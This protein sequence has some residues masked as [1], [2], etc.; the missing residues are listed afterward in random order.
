MCWNGTEGSR[1]ASTRFPGGTSNFEPGIPA[2]A[3]E[4]YLILSNYSSQTMNLP[5]NF[6]GTADVSCTSVIVVT[7]NDAT[8]CPGDNAT[9]TASGATDYVW[10]PVDN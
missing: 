4:Q 2:L 7:V 8:I 9:L 5:L 6:F 1:V 10:S 3:G